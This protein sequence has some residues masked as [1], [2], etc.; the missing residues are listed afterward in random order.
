MT[1]PEDLAKLFEIGPDNNRIFGYFAKPAVMVPDETTIFVLCC[2]LLDPTTKKPSKHELYIQILRRELG[3]LIQA[4]RG[5]ADHLGIEVS[6][7][8]PEPHRVPSEQN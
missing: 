7:G 8:S 6:E 3:P 1:T 4:L 5:A 2:R